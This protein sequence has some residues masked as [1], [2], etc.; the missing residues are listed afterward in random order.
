LERYR[1]PDDY[2]ADFRGR[3]ERLLSRRRLPDYPV[4]VAAAWSIGFDGLRA[5]HPT[6]LDLLTLLAWLGPEP[7]PTNL[8]VCGEADRLEAIRRGVGSGNPAHRLLPVLVDAMVVDTKLDLLTRRA[9]SP[10]AV[11]EPLSKRA[12]C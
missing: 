6:A 3:V 12:R 5:S 2:L 1:I 4:S 7:V 10:E 11:A 9:M 8:L